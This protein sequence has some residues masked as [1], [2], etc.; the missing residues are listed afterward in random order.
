V[1]PLSR[2]RSRAARRGAGGGTFA[3]DA[4]RIAG[5]HQLDTVQLNWT[6]TLH[7]QT[8]PEATLLKGAFAQD[9]TLPR[10]G[11]LW[12]TPAERRGPAALR[13]WLLC[14][15]LTQARLRQPSACPW[16]PVLTQR[17]RAP[18][19]RYLARD[20]IFTRFWQRRDDGVS[21]KFPVCHR[22]FNYPQLPT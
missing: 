15:L 20:L 2:V 3:R 11:H 16:N 6:V 21:S 8:P 7:S 1:R 13:Q 4:K 17:D 5:R 14:Q 18:F 9:S 19:R 22:N 12:R 10:S